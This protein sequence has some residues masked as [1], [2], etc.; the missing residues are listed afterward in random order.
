MRIA[1]LA[2]VHGNLA[3][4]EA[5]LADIASLDVD[6]IVSCG[7]TVLGAPD[8]Y[9]CWQR[10]KETTEYAVRGNTEGFVAQF[11]S[12]EAD[13]RWTTEQFGP[14]RYTVGQ[15]SDGERQ[16][17]GQMPATLKLPGVPDMLFYHAS[18]RNDRDLWRPHAPDEELAQYFGGVTEQ[19]LVGG[20][21]HTQQVRAWMGLRLCGINR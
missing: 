10:V 18:P 9:A 16:E 4:L 1:A 21:S 12:Q 20:H 11:G 2:D 3:A 19:V 17:L 15:F 5:V 7:D 14:L 8:D 13:P 6:H